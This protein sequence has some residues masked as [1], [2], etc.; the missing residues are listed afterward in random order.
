MKAFQ[1]FLVN[2]FANWFDKAV[3]F[4]YNLCIILVPGWTEDFVAVFVWRVQQLAI[5]PPTATPL[6][7]LQAKDERF[8]ACFEDWAHILGPRKFGRFTS[9]HVWKFRFTGQRRHSDFILV[10]KFE[11]R[12]S[13]LRPKRMFFTFNARERLYFILPTS[14][15]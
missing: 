6:L 3:K 1:P 8:N 10:G 7:D 2:N 15:W 13:I 11:T 14:R 4:S 5:L 9:M 12:F